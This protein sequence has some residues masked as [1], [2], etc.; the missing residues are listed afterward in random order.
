[1]KI[2]IGNKLKE[3]LPGEAR[4]IL[5]KFGNTEIDLG[6][7]N[8]R[9]V[10]K[11]ALENP[12]TLYIGMDPIEKQLRKYSRKALRKKLE[13]VLFVLGSAE[14]IPQELTETA[15]KVTIILPWGSLLEAVAK[16]NPK[17]IEAIK[18][19]IKPKGTLLLVFGYN[20]LEEPSETKRLG[21][22][23]LNADYIKTELIPRYENAGFEVLSF[24]ELTKNELK[25]INTSWSKKLSSGKPRSIFYLKF[26][27]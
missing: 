1:V 19:L 18:N 23:E 13:N 5:S 4:T 20:L 9:Y 6:T 26:K 24:K 22:E 10:Y 7:G 21:L 25:E 12:E 15:D 14:N 8:G 3:I 16:F 27:V 2:V 11:K 17:I